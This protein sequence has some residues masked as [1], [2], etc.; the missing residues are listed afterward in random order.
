M[1]VSRIKPE[2]LVV[3]EQVPH[4]SAETNKISLDN[5]T[6]HRSHAN[7]EH[8]N[9]TKSTHRSLS[10]WNL[11][12]SGGQGGPENPIALDLVNSIIVLAEVYS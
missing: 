9:K 12:A 7:C 10:S 11:A 3:W 4:S 2:V 5:A 6:G 8:C 1:I